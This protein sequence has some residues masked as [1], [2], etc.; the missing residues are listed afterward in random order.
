MSRSITIFCHGGIGN[1]FGSLASGLAIA[2]QLSITDIT[3]AWP[4]NNW[5]GCYFHDLFDNQDFKVNELGI[6][7]IFVK[8]TGQA[9]V[10]HENQTGADLGLVLPHTGD[11]LEHLKTIDNSIVFYHN[12][13]APYIPLDQIVSATNRLKIKVDVKQQV[14]AFIQEH[15]IDQSV[16]GLHLRKTENYRLNDSK[17]YQMACN[18]SKQKYF[19]C[20]DDQATEHNFNQLSNVVC[21][22]KTSY[23]NKLIDG[24]WQAEI[25][26]TDGR[27]YNYNI[28]RPRQS[29]IEAFVDM[30]VL[31]QTRMH[32]TVKSSFSKFADVFAQSQVLL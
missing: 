22:P 11:S 27:R 31:S 1:R 6:W 17:L 24:D 30:L 18:N 23:V 25:V 10:I 5:C 19:V 3:V 9:F 13:M 21:Y 28:D 12:K 20:S 32:F 16:V 26:D 8:D 7:D 14:L 29:V 2:E 15:N 4:I